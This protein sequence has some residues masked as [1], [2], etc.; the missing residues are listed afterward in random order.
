MK[1]VAT[2]EENLVK[3]K[4]RCLRPRLSLDNNDYMSTKINEGFFDTILVLEHYN[5]NKFLY[6]IIYVNQGRRKVSLFEQKP[7]FL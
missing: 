2:I 3:W 7:V 6:T 5:G 4:I 1:K